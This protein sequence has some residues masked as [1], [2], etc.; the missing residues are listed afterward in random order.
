MAVC[1]VSVM[2]MIGFTLTHLYNFYERKAAWSPFR[3]KV[4]EWNIILSLAA[5]QLSERP[6]ETLAPGSVT[7]A[8]SE[9]E[10][11]YRR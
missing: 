11:F 4:W 3:G 9:S 6:A 10:S 7:E 2:I 5:M 1:C 8:K